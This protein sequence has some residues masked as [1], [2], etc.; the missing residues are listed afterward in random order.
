MHPEIIQDLKLKYLVLILYLFY[1]S[2]MYLYY[3]IKIFYILIIISNIL[4]IYTSN[5]SNIL[6]Y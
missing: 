6:I 2:V 5:T 1:A 3:S 4:I